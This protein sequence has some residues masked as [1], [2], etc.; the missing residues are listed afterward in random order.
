MFHV[1]VRQFP[2]LAR[3]FNLT[4]GELDARLVEPWIAGRPVELQDRR[5]S[6]ERAR[7]TIYEGPELGVEEI[8]LGRGWA[9]VTRSGAEVTEAVLA[10]ARRQVEA[11]LPPQALKREIV[12]RRARGPLGLGD[13]VALAGSGG[14]RASARL[15]AAE[16]AVWEL[17]HEG[18]IALVRGS[19]ALTREQWQ[20]VLLSWEAWRDPGLGIE[21]LGPEQRSPPSA[22]G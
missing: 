18:A 12:A 20:P 16:Q 22:R 9:N 6:P 19:T 4:R 15:A 2:H 14:L 17:L 8:G 10:A 3:A 21:L 13:V 1:Q 7:L 11:P 5:W